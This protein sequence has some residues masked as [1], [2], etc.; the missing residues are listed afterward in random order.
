MRIEDGIIS[1]VQNPV[2]LVQG[3]LRSRSGFVPTRYCPCFLNC[4]TVKVQ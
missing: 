1:I 3:L 4:T 2:L